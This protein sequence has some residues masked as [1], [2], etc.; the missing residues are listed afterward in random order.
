MND[1]C[2]FLDD[3]FWVNQQTPRVMVTM[4][5]C[6]IIYI[7]TLYL[8]TWEWIENVSLRRKYYLEATHYSNR[9]N[10]LNKLALERQQRSSPAD[11][12]EDD[13]P[14]ALRRSMESMSESVR[15]LNT[16]LRS[17]TYADR[18][19]W[20]PHPE[21]RETPPSIGIFSVLY[22]LPKSLVTFDTDGATTLERQLVATTNFFNEIIRPDPG[23]SSS[24]AAVTVVPNAKLVDRARSRWNAC[25]RKLQKLRYIRRIKQRRKAEQEAHEKRELK[26]KSEG[27]LVPV[28]EEEAQ[29]DSNNNNVLEIPSRVFNI[30]GGG[31]SSDSESVHSSEGIEITP[32]TTNSVL[33]TDSTI[34][35]SGGNQTTSILRR[36]PIEFRYEFFDIKAYAPSVG[37]HEEVHDISDFVHGMGIEEFHVFARECADLAGKPSLD[38]KNY[39]HYSLE[40][41]REEEGELLKELREANLELQE[42]R[43]KVVTFKDDKEINDSEAILN[44]SVLLI[45]VDE[46]ED[47][48]NGEVRKY[49]SLDS[50]FQFAERIRRR[51][52]KTSRDSGNPTAAMQEGNGG[53][54]DDRKKRDGPK[55]KGCIG[56][57][58]G[59]PGRVY[60]GK[61]ASADGGGGG[62]SGTGGDKQR[63][64]ELLKYYGLDDPSL[65]SGN[66]KGFVTNLENPSYAV[67][68]F[69]TRQA[70]VIA[71]QCLADGGA[72]NS[73]K[74]VD[75][76]PVY[77]LADA[78]PLHVWCVLFCGLAFAICDF[79]SYGAGENRGPA[80]VPLRRCQ[81][82]FPAHHS[83]HRSFLF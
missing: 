58:T 10:E 47:D 2:N 42:A 28:R 16:R 41:L 27:M 45:E 34:D 44:P 70:A 13:D 37:F 3:H 11:E 68:T 57:L 83:H 81:F 46:A 39:D 24:V 26:R 36:N 48:N 63:S 35:P 49:G 65:R 4:I 79:C 22:Q 52:T 66:G 76:I 31:G 17:F 29:L 62:I 51:S 7:Y 55:K 77:P 43:Q 73:W 18:P 33:L 61:D 15:L 8:V 54:D 23:F 67:I 71:R 14:E 50:A 75:D 5:S 69:T 40:S 72:R 1:N 53:D 21:I 60:H 56:C 9:M 59:L 32:N 74:H 78:P 64:R 80:S 12:D 19:E 30:D 20:R 6:L 38:Q 82:L 25:A